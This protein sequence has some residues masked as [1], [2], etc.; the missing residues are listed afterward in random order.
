MRL[1]VCTGLLTAFSGFLTAQSPDESW[2]HY[3]ADFGVGPAIP[4]GNSTNYFSTA[5]LVVVG[6]GYRLN[7]WFQADVGAQ[8]AFGAANNQNLEESALGPVQG[9]DHEFMIPMGG[10]VF[11]PTRFEKFEV[12]AGAGVAYLHYSETVPSNYYV[13]NQCYSC[14][15]RDGW[16]AYG[17]ANVNYFLDSNRNFSVGT[18]LQY[19]IGHTSGPPVG[20]IPG[21]K[22]T[23]HWLNLMFDFGVSFK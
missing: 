5:P 20:A 7:R 10:R 15:A 14:T 17:L 18:T 2:H 3:N 1:W 6:F 16:G 12:S 23:D 22:T 21:L 9:G 19:I 8:F 11:I 4:L 13:A